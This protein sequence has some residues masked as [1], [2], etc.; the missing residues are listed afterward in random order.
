MPENICGAHLLE[1]GKDFC[2]VVVAMSSRVY[3]FED[4]A[5]ELDSTSN[6]FWQEERLKVKYA[7]RKLALM[8]M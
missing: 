1:K 6:V 3:F 4:L 8:W 2:L 5:L 7:A